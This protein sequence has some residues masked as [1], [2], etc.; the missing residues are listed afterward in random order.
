MAKADSPTKTCGESGCGRPLRAR[1]LCATHYNQQRYTA[2][3]RHRKVK[4]PCAWCDKPTYKESGR[5][6]RYAN[7]FCT[8]SCRDSW[9]S[10][11]AGTNVCAIPTTA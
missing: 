6:K 8:L 9:R 2:A 7:T 5:T 1:G 4:V 10:V 11:E 3:E